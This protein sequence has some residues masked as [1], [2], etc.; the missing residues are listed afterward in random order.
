MP[1]KIVLALLPYWNPFFP[2]LGISCIKGQ[3][4]THGYEVK[5][6][7][8]NVL[9][10][11]RKIYDQYFQVFRDL[12]P[13]YHQGNLYNI[14]HDVMQN[15]MMA[16]LNHKDPAV[17][18]NVLEGLVKKT[19]YCDFP[20]ELI[21]R[22]E[23]PIVQFYQKLE[24]FVQEVL[25]TESPDVFGLSVFSGALPA[26]VFAFKH[27]RRHFPHIKTVMGG[28]IFAEHLAPGSPN[29]HH[30]LEETAGYIDKL[31]VGEGEVL[32][33]KYLRDELPPEKRV[34]TLQDIDME[35]ME[36]ATAQV[37]DF[38]DYDFRYYPQLAFYTSR[39]C[40]FKCAFC[41]ETIQWGKFRKKDGIQ[42][43]RELVSLHKKHKHQLFLMGD[44]L[45]N[46]TI[47]SFSNELLKFDEAVY[48]DGYLRIDKNVC[49]MENT[50]LWRR[51]GLM[52]A[53]LGIESVSPRVLDLMDK[54]LSVDDIRQAVS[55]LASA[56][57][58]TSTMW[59]I[60]FPGE[61]E[62][63]FQAMLDFLEEMKDDVY[64]VDCNTFRYFLKGQAGSDQWGYKNVP[65]YPEDTERMLL[66]EHW[67]L[68]CQPS[69]EV[70]Y[71][72]H[73]R[74]MEHCRK[75]GIPNPYFMLDAYKADERWKALHENAVPSIVEFKGDAYVDECKRIEPFQ[76]AVQTV[77]DDGDF[78][79]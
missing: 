18:R 58:K 68:D 30:F 37:P 7:D 65:L 53:R 36:I 73:C 66:I 44:S 11:F 61:T 52:R 34:Y 62:E 45:M 22:L 15:H 76:M 55:A 20:D 6:I 8:A 9:E 50:F 2:P 41:S 74:L 28:G 26:S 5:T 1:K 32:L 29:Y 39:S 77:E 79:L 43:A 51:A 27:C 38:T 25:E 35:T 31:F 64:Q 33:L 13:E 71:D 12:I 70:M 47:T 60:G 46:P 10:D 63:D 67:K 42:A 19:F 14:G 57:I 3:L 17:Y 56:G 40:P 78:C 48:W 4:Q 24:A 49:N 54:K 21:D 72:R 59:L 75:L 69:R 16:Y 23:P